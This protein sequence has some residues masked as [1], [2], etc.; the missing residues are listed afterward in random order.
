M[1]DWN[2]RY[3]FSTLSGLPHVHSR[4]LC[5]GL[6]TGKLAWPLVNW[7]GHLCNLCLW[8]PVI[9]LGL[10]FDLLCAHGA[11]YSFGAR[12]D[13]YTRSAWN[14]ASSV[15]TYIYIYIYA[16]SR[17]IKWCPGWLWI[18]I[19]QELCESGG[20]RPGLSVLMS[21]LVSVDVKLYWTMLR[22]WS[23]LVPNMSSDIRG[24]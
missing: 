10:A 2:W 5:C 9:A 8:Q 11:G 6:A 17:H 14:S 15:Y 20:G 21:L 12:Q 18:L 23:Q 7:L 24:H 19:V 1:K 4:M 13:V 22:H 16:L 3:T